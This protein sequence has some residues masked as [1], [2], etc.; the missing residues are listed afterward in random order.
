M[1]RAA[2]AAVNAPVA[3]IG[4]WMQTFTGRQMWPLDPQVRDLDIVDI[5]HAL[6]MACRYAGH[7]LKFYSVAEHSV[8]MARWLAEQGCSRDVLL[9]AL[10]HDAPEAYLVDVPRPV[11]P[12][13]KG[14]AEFEDR[15]WTAICLWQEIP[16]RMAEEVKAADNRILVDEYDQNM[17]H[18][19]PW[20][21]P[22]T[23]LGVQIHCWEPRRAT[24]AFLAAY[25]QIKLKGTC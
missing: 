12:F 20:N 7:C 2:G 4:D 14:Y 22:F 1:G 18:T 23:A 13:L 16:T 19:V 15:L 5:A 24:A 3:R 10:L 17:R 8:L 21:L 11:K 9:Q 6:G 25:Q